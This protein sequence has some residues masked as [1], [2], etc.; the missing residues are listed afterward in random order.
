VRLGFIGVGAMGAPMAERLLA[1][2]HELAVFDPN[3]AAVG[4]SACST[5]R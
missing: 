4:A 3:G 1:A 5:P 2:G